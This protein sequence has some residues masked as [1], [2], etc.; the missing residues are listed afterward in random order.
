MSDEYGIDLAQFSLKEFR[1]I[2]ETGEVLPGRMVLKEKLAERFATLESIGIGNLKDLLDALKSNDKIEKLAQQ[3]AL[4]KDYLVML[5][6]EANSYLPK[7]LKLSEIPGVERVYTD[8]LASV[9][10]KNTQQL[11][12]RAKTRQARA[13]LSKLADVPDAGLLELV[14]LSDLARIK[15]I[16]PIF[17]R[18]FYEAGADTPEKLVERSPDE[19]FEKMQAINHAKMYTKTM[20]TVKDVAFCITMAKELPKPI[21][22]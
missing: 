9:G 1:H 18:L 14:K 8:R 12:V 15:Y 20:A 22:Y 10:I 6:R 21:E 4:P 11:F 7:P 5:R 19:L 13:E 17:V 16:G 2:L 3:S